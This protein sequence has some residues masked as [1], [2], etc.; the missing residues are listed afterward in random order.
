MKMKTAEPIESIEF[1]NIEVAFDNSESVFEDLSYVVPM[2]KNIRV[3]GTTGVGKSLLLKLIAGLVQPIRG[4]YLLNGRSVGDMS[5]EEF[6]PY[7]LNI[8]YSFEY[9]GLL[10]N[11]SLLENILLPTQYHTNY[12]RSNVEERAIDLM[13]RGDIYKNAHLRPSMVPGSH[14]KMTILIRAFITRPQMLLLDEPAAGLTFEGQRFIVDLIGEERASG[15]L[16]NVIFVSGNQTFIEELAETNIYL[17]DK[18]IISAVGA[19][20]Q[21]AS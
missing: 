5:F 17:R 7:R 14:R 21:E 11:K 1:R 3:V 6:T 13:K 15:Y 16:K 12:F 9:G 19:L 2:R 10:N 8:G 18:Q 4:D 20:R